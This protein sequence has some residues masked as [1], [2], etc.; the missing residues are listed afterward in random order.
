MVIT[1]SDVYAAGCCGDNSGTTLP[2]Y[3]LNGNWVG[4]AEPSGLTGGTVN[5]LVV[6][7]GNVYAAGAIGNTPSYWLNGNWG[8][9]SQPPGTMSGAITSLAISGGTIYSAGYTAYPYSALYW[10][11]DTTWVDLPPLTTQSNSQVLSLVLSGS[12]VYAGGWSTGSGAAQPGYWLN[13]TWVSL[14]SPAGTI[15]GGVGSLVVT[16]GNV[17]AGGSVMGAPDGSPIVPGYW[18]NGAWTALTP[19]PG[20]D[21]CYIHGMVVGD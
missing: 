13:G 15:G 10:L 18:L 8:G 14:G 19:S 4:L 20:S 1:G 21:Y 3:W 11:N 7:G 17:F 6:V 2:G 9:Y 12:D 5:S 16:G